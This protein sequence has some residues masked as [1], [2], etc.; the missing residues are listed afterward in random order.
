MKTFFDK[1]AQDEL[2]QRFS[3]LNEKSESQ[4][5]KMSAAQM[6][7]HCTVAM[8]TPVG[9]IQV[10]GP[11]GLSLIGRMFKG[12]LVSDK[13]FS[14]NSPTAKEFLMRDPRDFAAES[15]RFQKAFQKL[16]QGPSLITCHKHPFFGNMST[17]D[18]GHLMYKHLDHHFRQF[19]V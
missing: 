2:N 14:K 19:G 18:W 1:N 17:D 12:M 10:K 6:L 16:A 15:D 13:P 3:K 8:Q 5:G 7:A 11:W 9:D 4:W